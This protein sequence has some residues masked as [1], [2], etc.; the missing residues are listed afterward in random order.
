[1]LLLSLSIKKNRLKTHFYASLQHNRSDSLEINKQPFGLF[2]CTENK[3]FDGWTQ[4]SFF[5]TKILYEIITK[6]LVL[7][8]DSF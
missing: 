1:M 6:F 2:S 3:L 8:Q 7:L 4:Y 5:F